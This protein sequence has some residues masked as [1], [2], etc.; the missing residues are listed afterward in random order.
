MG[1]I[2]SPMALTEWKR[3]MNATQLS[4]EVA[5]RT[6][7]SR[8][9]ASDATKAVLDAMS[10]DFIAGKR[11]SLA[12]FGTFEIRHRSARSGRNPQ[13]GAEIRIPARNTVSF[14]PATRIRD[15]INDGVAG[16]G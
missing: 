4:A 2:P 15:A 6:G 13:T 12:G 8:S 16:E 14:R 11:V 10:A 1:E 5:A 9:A 7:L 3:L